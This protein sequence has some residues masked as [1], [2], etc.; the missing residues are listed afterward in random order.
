M[1][2]NPSSWEKYGFKYLQLSLWPFAK[3]KYQLLQDYKIQTNLRLSQEA[4]I[5]YIS[6][7]TSGMLTVHKG[8]IWNGASGPTWDSKCSMRA[9]CGHDAVFELIR[10]GIISVGA[11]TLTNVQFIKECV[12]DGMSR[13]RANLWYLFLRKFSYLYC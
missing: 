9:S 11:V 1:S 2:K 3:N 13:V 6:L 7:S 8:F 10:L 4:R 12:E 5:P